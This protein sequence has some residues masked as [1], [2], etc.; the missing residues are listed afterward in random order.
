MAAGLASYPG[1]LRDVLRRCHA[2]WTDGTEGYAEQLGKTEFAPL[3]GRGRK[4]G[5]KASMSHFGVCVC[6]GG[7]G[8]KSGRTAKQAP[9]PDV[10]TSSAPQMGRAAG[11]GSCSSTP[12]RKNAAPQLGA[13]E[14]VSS[15]PVSVR[16]PGVEHYMLPQWFLGSEA[17]VSLTGGLHSA[18]KARG[19]LW[20]HRPRSPLPTGRPLVTRSELCFSLVWCG[21]SQ[22]LWSRGR[23]QPRPRVLGF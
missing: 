5:S 7:R 10:A 11:W 4:K 23:L 8:A 9:W 3:S 22:S 21:P 19:P 13:L 6:G 20:V 16:P 12:A 17:R 14:A 1:R 2:S 18:G 15:P